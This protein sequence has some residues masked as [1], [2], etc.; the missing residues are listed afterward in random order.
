MKSAVICF[1]R[2]P[3]AGQTKTRL[4]PILSPQQCETLHTAFLKDLADV[5]KNIEAD[6]FVAYAPDPNPDILKKIFPTSKDFFQQEGSD[7]GE[8]MLNAIKTVLNK[9]YEACILSGSD[10]PMMTSEHLNSGFYAL[11][12]CDITLGPT[13]DGGYY[14]VGMKK[15]C[16]EIFTNQTYGNSTV[17]ENTLAAIEKTKYSFCSALPCDDVDTPDDLRQL[18]KLTKGHNSHTAEFLELLRKEGVVLC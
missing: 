9:G 13:S 11:K 14:L 4:L 12:T 2:V 8:K 18:Y 15:I 7:L 17:W 6:L 16:P 3:R 5:Y 1:T 10:L